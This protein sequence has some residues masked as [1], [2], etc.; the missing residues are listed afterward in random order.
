MLTFR[1]KLLE[2][3]SNSPDIFVIHNF[4]VLCIG[5]NG[6]PFVSY[7]DTNSRTA[8]SSLV[9][10]VK[11]VLEMLAGRAVLTAHVGVK[12]LTLAPEMRVRLQ[13]RGSGWR[14][15]GSR[16]FPSTSLLSIRNRPNPIKPI[17]IAPNPLKS[18]PNLP[19][20]YT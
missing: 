18:T 5:A 20:T 15:G 12:L 13:N 6:G 3:G 4:P 7:S 14:S 10:G 16:E 2:I 11:K 17:E 1:A 9:R 19:V 8:A